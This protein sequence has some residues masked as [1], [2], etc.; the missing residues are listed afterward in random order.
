[1]SFVK[2]ISY[3]TGYFSG[4][5]G[6]LVIALISFLGVSS[7]H[8]APK[9]DTALVHRVY[10]DGEFDKAIKLIESALA[11]GAVTS[12]VDSVF[13]LKHLGVMYTARYETREIGKKYMYQLLYIEPTARIMDMYASDMIYMIFKNIQEEV[14]ITR[15]KPKPDGPEADPK[16]SLRKKRAWPYWVG[17]T[18]AVG[19]G[20]ALASYFLLDREP[21]HGTDYVVSQ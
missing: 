20:L 12:H 7:A 15:A 17:G 11:T 16:P 1:V 6:F 4:S 21:R 18:V 13:A 9:F 5:M 3:F 8:S 14:A 2:A 10:M 19:A